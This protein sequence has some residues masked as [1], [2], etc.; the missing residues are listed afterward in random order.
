VAEVELE[1]PAL[2]QMEPTAVLAVVVAAL[3]LTETMVLVEV[4]H[5]T[6]GQMEVVLEMQMLA[7]LAVLT[8]AAAV[9]VAVVV[10]LALVVQT[11]A[12]MV[13]QVFVWFLIPYLIYQQPQQ[14]LIQY[15]LLALTMCTYLLALEQSLSKDKKWKNYK[16]QHNFSIH[17]LAI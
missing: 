7:V 12:V 9:V 4:Q 6:L 2:A 8:Q 11:V 13:V 1:N 14:E 16:S 3:L 5:I 17:L 15:Q 10:A